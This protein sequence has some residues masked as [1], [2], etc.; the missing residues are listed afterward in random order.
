MTRDSVQVGSYRPRRRAR[1]FISCIPKTNSPQWRTQHARRI[2]TLHDRKGGPPPAL[3]PLA[4]RETCGARDH[5]RSLAPTW[6][7]FTHT[8]TCPDCT[9]DHMCMRRMRHTTPCTRA[10]RGH[11]HSVVRAARDTASTAAPSPARGTAGGI[12]GGTAGDDGMSAGARAG[13]R[14][15]CTSSTLRVPARSAC[16]LRVPG[17]L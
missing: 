1:W 14:R 7:K 17:R 10:R 4:A 12:A 3:P 15:L 9:P 6:E 16:P 5:A 8:H 2:H 11:G 13:R